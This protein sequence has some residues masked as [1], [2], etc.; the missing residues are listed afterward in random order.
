LYPDGTKV[1]EFE[2]GTVKKIMPDGKVE[3]VQG[4][5]KN[6]QASAG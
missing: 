5:K 6:T 2:D 3:I 4:N 1:R